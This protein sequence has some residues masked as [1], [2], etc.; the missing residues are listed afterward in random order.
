MGLF[1]L[2]IVMSTNATLQY[3][4]MLMGM[5]MGISASPAM[6]HYIKKWKAR[7]KINKILREIRESMMINKEQERAKNQVDEKINSESLL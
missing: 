2:T 1:F 5:G 3:E 4:S 6:T 7:R